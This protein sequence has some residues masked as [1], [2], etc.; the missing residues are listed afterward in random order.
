[1]TIQCFCKHKFDKSQ[2]HL[3]YR[4][5]KFCLKHTLAMVNIYGAL[6]NDGSMC[7]GLLAMKLDSSRAE[8]RRALVNYYKKEVPNAGK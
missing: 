7:G 3:V 5:D 8:V 6:P 4:D 1:M 2:A